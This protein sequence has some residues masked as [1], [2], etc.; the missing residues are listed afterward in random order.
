MAELKFDASKV[1]KF[2]H[3]GWHGLGHYIGHLVQPNAEDQVIFYDISMASLV[4]ADWHCPEAEFVKINDCKD[5]IDRIKTE[6]EPF[7]REMFPDQVDK[8]LQV[9]LTGYHTLKEIL[10]KYP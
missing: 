2:Y 8:H 9:L 3:T 10:Q 7:L 6:V 1:S 5:M 4:V